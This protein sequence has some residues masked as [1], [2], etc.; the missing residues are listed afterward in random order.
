MSSK[1]IQTVSFQ[2][3]KTIGLLFFVLLF[4]SACQN[5]LSEIEKVVPREDAFTETAHDVRLVYSDS[6]VVKVQVEGPKMVR[7]LAKEDPRDE[8]PGGIEVSFFSG[9]RNVNSTLTS[10]FAVRYEGKKQITVRDSVVW[11]SKKGEKLETEELIWNEDDEKVHS[12]RYV[13]ITNEEEIIYGYGFEANQDFTEWR[14]KQIEGRMKVE[15]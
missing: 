3:G 11:I 15:E 4:L 13:R 1:H 6:A 12:N 10:K 8:F 14:I 5:D 9:G 2:K 7:Y